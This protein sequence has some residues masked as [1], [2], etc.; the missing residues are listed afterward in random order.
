[1]SALLRSRC[2]PSKQLTSKGKTSVRADN[3]AL[4]EISVRID[5]IAHAMSPTSIHC[6]GFKHF[7]APVT[8]SLN[9]RSTR[10][11][12][13]LRFFRWRKVPCAPVVDH[14]LC[15]ADSL[16]PGPS[17]VWLD[18]PNARLDDLGHG[19]RRPSSAGLAPVTPQPLQLFVLCYLT[20]GLSPPGLFFSPWTFRNL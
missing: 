16:F 4:P 20:L 1:M 3:I 5:A 15:I 10:A 8:T 18:P 17:S 14:N 13:G 9:S 7:M 19:R 2:V 6:V 11:A 12:A